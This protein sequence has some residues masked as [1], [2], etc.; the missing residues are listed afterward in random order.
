MLQSMRAFVRRQKG[1]RL[2][3]YALLV[4]IT[5]PPRILHQRLCAGENLF[6]LCGVAQG[7]VAHG[8]EGQRRRRP[9]GRSR[10][11]AVSF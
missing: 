6:G 11:A 9:T 1:D 8:Q 2:I 4:G 10:I 5:R 7:V 3:H